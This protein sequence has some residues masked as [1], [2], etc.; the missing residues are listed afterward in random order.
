MFSYKPEK[1]LLVKGDRKRII[2]VLTN[3]VINGIKYGKKDGFIKVGF[4]DFDDKIMIEVSDNG[5]GIDKK[6][7]PRIFERFFRVD[8]SRSREQGGTVLCGGNVRPG[9]GFYVEPTGVGL[10]AAHRLLQD[11]LFAPFTAVCAVDSLDEALGHANCK[12]SRRQA[13]PV[14]QSSLLRRGISATAMP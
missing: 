13:C 14:R 6:D 12:G 8:K 11:E 2:E 5:L 9:Q 10:P 4:Y 3:L 1:P 7:L